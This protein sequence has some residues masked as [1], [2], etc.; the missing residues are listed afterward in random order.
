M[1]S[2]LIKGILG[3]ILATISPFIVLIVVGTLYALLNMIGGTTFT[4]SVRSFAN[5]IISL[6]PFLPYLTTIPVVLVLLIV[7]LKRR[8]KDAASKN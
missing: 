6:K 7:V 4:V 3:I 2:K 8:R 5:F 1:K